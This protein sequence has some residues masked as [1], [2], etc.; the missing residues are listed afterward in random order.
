M[1]TTMRIT[2]FAPILAM[3]LLAGGTSAEASTSREIP[4]DE[5][6]RALSSVGALT[7]PSAH[8]GQRNLTQEPAIEGGELL[9]PSLG[10]S[11]VRLAPV[12]TTPPALSS[13][14]LIVFS[15][16]DHSLSLS[17]SA[18]GANAGYVII[19]SG[20][21]PTEYRFSIGVNGQPAVLALEPDGGVLVMSA[22]G[23]V[24]N[25]IA[26]PWAVDAAGAN[27]ETSY[28]ISGSELIQ[29]VNHAGAQYPVVAD[30]RLQCDAL[31][32][33]WEYTRAETQIFAVW[34]STASILMGAGCA[35]LG[36]VIA[37]LACAVAAAT[38]QAVAQ[39]ALNQGK[40]VGLRAFHYAR[41]AFPVIVN[42]YA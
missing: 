2:A 16:P 24:V 39:D 32:C 4:V 29:V 42:C 11:E 22:S 1:M 26:A 6:V 7:P 27:V 10:S 25:R 3:L 30:P 5:V 33:T 31:F 41:V 13:D 36:G 34:G 9:V 19:A 20:R 12:A 38:M 35:A 8:S 18:R 28:V 14:G 17:T 21:A 15:E 40:C 37:G 23:Q